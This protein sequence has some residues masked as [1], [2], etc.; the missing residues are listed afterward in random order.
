M[1]LAKVFDIYHVGNEKPLEVVLSVR[2]N[3]LLVC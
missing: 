1:C 2:D 3:K